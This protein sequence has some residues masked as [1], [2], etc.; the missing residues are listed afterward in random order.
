MS[1]DKT[2]NKIS[3]KDVQHLA[4]LCRLRL[5]DE[6]VER[7]SR[8][9]SSIVDYMEVLNTIDTSGVAPLYSPAE[10]KIQYRQDVATHVRTRDEVLANA[11]ERDEN[12]FIV[13]RIV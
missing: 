3:A 6:D 1:Q 9:L 4:Q 12:Y 11:P 7:F 2:E 13:P 8:Q 10:H 5:S